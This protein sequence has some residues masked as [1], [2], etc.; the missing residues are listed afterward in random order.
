MIAAVH[1]AGL[2]AVVALASAL[3]IASLLTVSPGAQAGGA[4]VLAPDL[5]TLAI[6][7]ENLAIEAEEGRTLLRLSNE[8]GNIGVG[9]LEVFPSPASTDCDAD[10]DPENDR[11]ASQRLFAD[12]NQS[13]A[14]EGES[15]EIASERLFGCLRY[16]P[17]H[18]HWHTLDFARYELRR[19]PDGRMM[20]SRRK[21]GFCVGDFRL[22]H[23][24]TTSAPE[25]SYPFGSLAERGCDQHATQG[26]SPGWA[27]LY[28][29]AL[30]GQELDVGG[31][32]RGRYCLISRA[33]PLDV[34]AE[35]NERNNVRRLRIALRP[36]RLTVRALEEPCG[37]KR[38]GSS[39]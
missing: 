22:F 20:R 8:I 6:N 19:E 39:G 26:L 12:T 2:A 32:P 5:V 13:G 9:P 34:V 35:A 21:V 25:G 33:D 36:R 24:S 18:D 27:D 11:S 29:F 7:Q 3:G 1:R 30:P 31:L 17:A 38:S 10:A 14:F 16:H 28:A 37:T 15:D 23:P 4:A